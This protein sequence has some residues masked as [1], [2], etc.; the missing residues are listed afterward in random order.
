MRFIYVGRL[1][2]LKGI[3]T[4]IE[5]W[6]ILG[7]DAPVLDICGD[8]PL[9]KWCDGYIDNKSLK[10]VMMRGRVPNDEAKRLIASS[11]ALIMPT[12]LYEGF[13]MTIV[14]AYSSGTPVIGSDIG[15]TACLIREGVTGYTFGVGD[16]DALAEIIRAFNP[17]PKEPIYR[18][19]REKYSKEKNIEILEQI[20]CSCIA[21]GT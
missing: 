12:L 16:A 8:G 9:R 10:T 15:N 14:E 11:D 13:P 7:K 5:G 17:L 3:K 18:I 2:E 4:L 20:Y 6:R 21:R 1:D 19:Y